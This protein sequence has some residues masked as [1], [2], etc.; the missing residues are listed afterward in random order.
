MTMSSSTCFLPPPPLITITELCN[1]YVFFYQDQNVFD[2]KKRMKTAKADG[3]KHKLTATQQRCINLN[4][5]LLHMYTNQVCINNYI[6][7]GASS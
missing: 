6:S 7:T 2:S 4:Q 1:R 3:L 5:G